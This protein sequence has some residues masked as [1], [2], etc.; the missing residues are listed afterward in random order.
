VRDQIEMV[1]CRLGDVLDG[2]A[3]RYVPLS[4]FGLWKYLME[5]KHRK[6]VLIDAVSLWVPEEPTLWSSGVT[7]EDLEPVVRIRFMAE[8]LLGAPV[9]VERYFAALSYPQAQEALLAHYTRGQ[10]RLELVA[11]AGY[12]L[13]TPRLTAQRAA[14]ISA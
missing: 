12:F 2:A 9:P 3:Q 6:E 5:T 13:P 11:T 14:S 1:R 4:E 10:A 8:G 7:A